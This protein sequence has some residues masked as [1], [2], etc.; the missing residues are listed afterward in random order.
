MWSSSGKT[1]FEAVRTYIINPKSVDVNELYGSFNIQTL[2]WTDG[3]LSAIMRVACQDTRSLHK[4]IVL[5]G[6]VDTLWIESMNSL[7]DDNKTLTLINGDRIA[8]PPQVNK[9]DALRVVQ[10]R[11][12][13]ATGMI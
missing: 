10:Q 7:L 9:K 5:D 12:T 11:G 13:A 3:I 8:M 4:W 6:P 1:E 2:E